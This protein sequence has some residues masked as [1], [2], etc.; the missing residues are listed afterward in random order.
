MNRFE[1]GVQT[2][3]STA[4]RALDWQMFSREDIVNLALQRPEVM[5]DIRGHA[6]AVRAWTR[7]DEAPMR[8][9]AGQHGDE[10]IAR[11]LGF[12]FMEYHTLRPLLRRIAPRKIADIGAGYGFFALFAHAEFGAEMTL[13]DTDQGG[14]RGFDYRHSSARLGNLA[15]AQRFLEANGC[16]SDAVQVFDPLTSDLAALMGLDL[17]TS[18][19]A[20]GYQFPCD[21]YRTLFEEGVVPG[22]HVILDIRTRHAHE[23][24]PGL[25]SLGALHRIGHAADGQA[26]RMHLVT[27]PGIGQNAA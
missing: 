3:Q 23:I 21:S 6:E 11:A 10:L 9:I 13:I 25:A 24:L 20:C 4:L 7:G 8:Y 17:V 15:V 18:F 27:R 12:V 19:L 5:Q 22:G 26:L 14:E 2:A 1:A 16:A